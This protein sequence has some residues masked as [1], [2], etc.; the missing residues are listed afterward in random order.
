MDP[1]TY[2]VRPDTGSPSGDGTVGNPFDTIQTALDTIVPVD[3]DILNCQGGIVRGFMQAGGYN[4]LTVQ[5]VPGAVQYEQRGSVLITGFAGPVSGAYTKNIGAGLNVR[6]AM[7]NY[8]AATT[9]NGSRYGFLT[10]VAN[11]AAV[12][13]SGK[14]FYDSGT[15]V[16]TIHVGADPATGTVEYAVRSTDNVGVL[17]FG[18][19]FFSTVNGIAISCGL[20]DIATDAGGQYGN[21]IKANTCDRTTWSNLPLYDGGLHM[22]LMS[23]GDLTGN[24]ISGCTYYGCAAN[25]IPHVWYS[26][27]GSSGSNEMRD[28]AMYL[29]GYLNI[30]GTAIASSTETV[31]L[32]TIYSHTG[33]GAAKIE[34][35]TYR[36]VTMTFL[37]GANG[38]I[39]AAAD[40][41]VTSSL[42]DWTTWSCKAID[43]TMTGAKNSTMN[44]TGMA[45]VN[46]DYR[47]GI[48]DTATTS[49]LLQGNHGFFGCLLMVGAQYIG[50]GL[51]G[52]GITAY[53]C[54]IGCT[55]ISRNTLTNAQYIF[56]PTGN[57]G[58]K[59]FVC[60]GNLYAFTRA[61]AGGAKTLYI[62]QTSG[63]GSAVF[64][65][66]N[67][68][69]YNL[70]TTTGD[71]TIY[72]FSTNP[73]T[74]ISTSGELTAAARIIKHA[75]AVPL[76][77][78]TSINSHRRWYKNYGAWQNLT[79][80]LRGRGRS[81]STLRGR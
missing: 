13:S 34:N 4:G 3:I 36:R 1:A 47:W 44:D 12:N 55:I 19:L 64:T 75:G 11:A 56:N 31:S 21:L 18:D 2:E 48:E 73:F 32:G 26:S 52:D 5:Q 10:L 63:T 8:G 67:N 35:L 20:K 30:D 53:A 81:R 14:Y 9:A 65:N 78:L 23:G 61:T 38:A 74:S 45:H 15:G 43:C 39:P 77:N 54:F 71:A 41:T 7:W 24:V 27:L 79:G 80:G 6:G 40:N 37:F 17:T 33:G 62:D 42:E 66:S 60:R 59:T 28:C 76:G 70:D 46:C 49:C 29:H 72:T 68:A 50:F 69:Q 51:Y 22:T 25:C 58:V 16:L 57:A